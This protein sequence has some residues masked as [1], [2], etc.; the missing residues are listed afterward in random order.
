M[1]G[2]ALEV[3]ELRDGPGPERSLLWGGVLLLALIELTVIASLI[4]SYFYLRMG[5]TFWPP[6]DVSLPSLVLPSIGQAALVLSAVPLA[7]ADRG[8]RAGRRPSLRW[9]LAPGLALA[10]VYLVLKGIEYAKLGYRWDSHVYGSINWTITAYQLLHIV[11]VLG[12][13]G[14]LWAL[15]WTPLRERISRTAVEALAL[16]WYFVAASSLLSFA[17][18]YGTPYV[19]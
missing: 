14:V 2:N 17:V 16:Y 11:I 1:R 15:S 8:Y 10:S 3:P 5:A 4:A 7:L 6:A 13:G 12:A 18:L 9:L 19:L